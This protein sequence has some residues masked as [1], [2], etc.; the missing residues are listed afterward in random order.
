MPHWRGGTTTT[1]ES[2]LARFRSC[3]TEL[4]DVLSLVAAQPIELDSNDW[5]LDFGHGDVFRAKSAV[6]LRKPDADR[7]QAAYLA[8]GL[9]R[10][11][12][13]W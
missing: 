5:P 4:G 13:T 12:R 9:L 7:Y 8:G 3:A 2:S 6:A 1:D 11:D 10:T